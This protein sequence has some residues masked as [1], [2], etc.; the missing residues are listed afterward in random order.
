MSEAELRRQEEES[1]LREKERAEVERHKLEQAE[2]ERRRQEEERAKK[3][4]ELEA[5]Q[6]TLQTELANLKG[7]FTGRRRR[8]IAIRLAE[9]EKS[10]TDKR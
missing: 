7:L 10:L 2:A 3:R 6:T 1:L 9:I 8:E 4:A 5:E